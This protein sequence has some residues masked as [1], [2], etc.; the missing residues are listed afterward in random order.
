MKVLKDSTS[1]STYI[2]AV[3]SN[4]L[5]DQGVTAAHVVSL[6][7]WRGGDEVATITPVDLAALGDPWVEGG[8]I[9]INGGCYRLDVPD[10][11]F[12]AGADFVLIGGVLSGL[13]SIEIIEI[14][15]DDGTLANTK[16]TLDAHVAN[17]T[18]GLGQVSVDHN[19]G[20]T[21]ALQITDG[22]AGIPNVQIAAYLKTNWDA[23]LRDVSYVLGSTSTDI[24][25][26]WQTPL[27]LDPET[28]VLFVYGSSDFQNFSMDVVVSS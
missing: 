11:A 13:S 26:R 12:A 10:A 15:I 9:R 7:Y 6:W 14:A 23:G 18:I 20:G 4:G 27:M 16:S 19:Y 24:N 3:F 5:P 1:V 21:D 22:V 17:A 2:R 25:G 28:Y 8:L